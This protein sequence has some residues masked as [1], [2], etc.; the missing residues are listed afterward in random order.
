MA[1]TTISAEPAI[2]FPGQP[3]DSGFKH[4]I[5]TLVDEANGIAPGLLVIRGTDV[6]VD[7]A[8]PAAAFTDAD[9]LGVSI[10]TH[11]ARSDG[12]LVDNE[13]YEDDTPM[14]VRRRGRV[15]VTVE[16]A[17][18]AGQQAYARHTAGAGGSDPGA[19]RTDDDTATASVVNGARFMSSGG[20]GEI[21]VLEVNLP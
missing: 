13:V 7:A 8:L 21:G 1:Q 14:P 20:A 3:A 15:Y 16:D 2:G 9:V 18:V 12:A 11:K 5:S 17:F 10:R 19:F 6:D 4:D